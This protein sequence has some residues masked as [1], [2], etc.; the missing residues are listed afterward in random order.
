MGL[1]RGRRHRIL[2]ARGG[3]ISKQAH[4]LE[5][6]E[7]KAETDGKGGELAAGGLTW[8]KETTGGKLEHHSRR[9]L[10][11]RRARCK[12]GAGQEIVRRNRRHRAGAR[13]REKVV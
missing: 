4:V 9:D 8:L 10:R 5:P 7:A 2:S 6:D 12:G 1:F 3:P 13:G 11:P